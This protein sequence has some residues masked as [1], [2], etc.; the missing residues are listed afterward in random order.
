MTGMRK[1]DIGILRAPQ[2]KFDFIGAFCFEFGNGKTE[3]IVFIEDGKLSYE[4]GFYDEIL[5]TPC[6]DDSMFTLHDVVIGVNFHWQR[7]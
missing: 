7:K 1:V 4:G 3:N 6:G 2:I 5:F